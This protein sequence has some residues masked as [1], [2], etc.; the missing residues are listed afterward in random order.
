MS[1]SSMKTEAAPVASRPAASGAKSEGETPSTKSRVGK[2]VVLVCPPRPEPLVP[3][4]PE[5]KSKS[6]K[7]TAALEEFGEYERSLRRAMSM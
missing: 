7:A 3:S 5:T 6:E 1:T 4:L 2:K